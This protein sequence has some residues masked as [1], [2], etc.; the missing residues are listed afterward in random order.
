MGDSARDQALVTAFAFGFV[1]CAASGT[2]LFHSKGGASSFIRGGLRLILAAFLL[3]VVLWAVGGFIGAFINKDFPAGCQ[4]AI[5]FASAFDQIARIALE[6]YLFWAMKQDLRATLGLWFPQIVIFLRFI[7]GGIFVGGLRPQFAPI[8]VAKN[9][10]WQVG[11]AASIAD[12]FIVFMLLVRAS[13]VG[14]FLQM[15]VDGPIGFRAKGLALTTIA[16]GLWIPLS[17][18]MTL[19]LA[20]PGIAARTALP[21]VGALLTI[22]SI[23]FFYKGLVWP[24]KQ[25]EIS[26]NTASNANHFPGLPGPHLYPSHGMEREELSTIDSAYHPPGFSRDRRDSTR[27]RSSISEMLPAAA[28]TLAGVGGKGQLFPPMKNNS[29]NGPKGV[30]AAGLARDGSRKTLKSVVESASQ[31]MSP[32]TWDSHS[33]NDPVRVSPGHIFQ[34][35]QADLSAPAP[36]NIDYRPQEESTNQKH[37]QG[38][39]PLQIPASSPMRPSQTI[40]LGNGF[41]SGDTGALKPEQRQPSWNGAENRESI[42]NRPRP[43]PRRSAAGAD[44][45]LEQLTRPSQH[46]TRH[47]S[48]NLSRGISPMLQATAGNPGQLQPLPPTRKSAGLLSSSTN[49]PTSQA[50]SA[51]PARKDRSLD[52]AGSQLVPRHDARA[53][54]PIPKMIASPYARRDEE[55]AARSVSKSSV[56][57][58]MSPVDGRSSA[59][60]QSPAL[61]VPPSPN[62]NSRRKSSPVLPVNDSQESA[63]PA[64]VRA[65]RFLAD[66]QTQ[67][68]PDRA[69]ELQEPWSKGVLFRGLE[70]S[71]FPGELSRTSVDEGNAVLDGDH[72]GKETVTVMLDRSAEY[73]LRQPTR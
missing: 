50:H 49:K 9:L 67:D 8:C 14:I 58:S 19:G 36:A 57:A 62:R 22:V 10:L 41:D 53:S 63:T 71:P 46:G 13:S 55:S 61:A 33:A 3:L 4:I 6:E 5:A 16:L 39:V 2:A 26:Q 42:M 72:D 15:K 38:T 48:S 37:S 12:S 18:P 1:V 40:V 54:S 60:L 32:S 65:G 11:L 44:A 51:L 52:A 45:G 29:H 30:A 43:V 68:P 47:S 31:N 34:H 20:S 17:V 28:Q 59:Y 64:S 73:T 24:Q 56:S 7:L 25:Q 35:V 23:A 69:V 21:S 66:S 70:V 27:T